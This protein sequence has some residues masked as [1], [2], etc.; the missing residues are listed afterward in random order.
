MEVKLVGASEGE[1]TA[2]GENFA[3]GGQNRWRYDTW[4]NWEFYP[5][6]GIPILCYFKETQTSPEGQIHFFPMIM[7]PMELLTQL[8]AR[9]PKPKKEPKE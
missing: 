8:R 2:T 1:L 3:V 7:D 9:V 5:T 4:V 6:I